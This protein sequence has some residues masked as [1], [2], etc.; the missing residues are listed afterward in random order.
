[1]YNLV[2]LKNWGC[3]FVFIPFQDTTVTGTAHWRCDRAIDHFA[4]FFI[5]LKTN[6]V[7]HI[8]GNGYRGALGFLD[9][10]RRRYA[11]GENGTAISRSYNG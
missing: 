6:P 7:G 9:A 2:L 5:A 3:C 1:M 4:V 11:D 8:P 10:N